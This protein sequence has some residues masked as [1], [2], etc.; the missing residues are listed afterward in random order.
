[1]ITSPS[2]SA[3]IEE[4]SGESGQLYSYYIEGSDRPVIDGFFN[5]A[6][7]GGNSEWAQAY[8]RTIRLFSEDGSKETNATVFFMN[9]AEYLYI[10][11]SYIYEN[12][13]NSQNYVEIFFDEGDGS[14]DYD[15][16]H[17]DK[18]SGSESAPNEQGVKCKKDTTT[19]LVDYSWNGTEWITDGDSS[20]DFE[21]EVE[22]DD[23]STQLKYEFKIPLNK[24]SDS[25]SASDLNIG[26]A[27]EL[28]IIIHIRLQGQTVSY[29]DYY[30]SL[31]NKD[32]SDA[33]GWGDLK[34]GVKKS[35]LTMYATYAINGSPKIDGDISNDFSWADAYEREMIFTNFNS[36]K[37][38]VKLLLV[39]DPDNSFVYI[40]LV[41]YDSRSSSGDRIMIH[42]EQNYTSLPSNNRDYIMDA[43]RENYL[44][45]TSG[46]EFVDGKF[47][48]SGGIA[49]WVNDTGDAQNE[50]Q[51]GSGIYY[52]SP[53]RYEFEFKLNYSAAADGFNKED[54]Y[55]S[56]GALVGM[57]IQYYDADAEHYPNYWWEYNGNCNAT[58]IDKNN[59]I[60]L[61]MGYSFLQL[62]GPA[63]KLITP[64][65]NGVASGNDYNYKI[66]AVDENTD[67]VNWCGFR[68]SGEITWVSLV[69]ET[70]SDIWYTTW[71]TTSYSNGLKDMVIVAQ[72]D[73]GIVVKRYIQVYI[74]NVDS[75]TPPAISSLG[76]KPSESQPLTGTTVGFTAEAANAD[77]V[78]F[79]VDSAW[80]GDMSEVSSGTY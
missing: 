70:S 48:A 78:K 68:I 71:D 38:K 19:L 55:L 4:N 47:T 53:D 77:G 49:E 2:A 5:S 6:G 16:E 51:T 37:L 41:V 15:G 43:D 42:F 39:E 54:L 61:A 23:V 69:K 67:G 12:S 40:G 52:L 27:D 7:G 25:T 59:N 28:G 66:M 11:I 34:L 9:D 80:V 62:G 20:T 76:L 74:S 10:G 63:I 31:T 32:I 56:N 75:G 30:W 58:I 13:G 14:S 22:G 44:T 46:G 79:Y 65:N 60:F 64:Q 36:S 73:D 8:L 50:E 21:A 29:T 72:D 57:Q 1:M 26:P 18:L 3:H 35:D 17:D 45:A 33:S 24:K